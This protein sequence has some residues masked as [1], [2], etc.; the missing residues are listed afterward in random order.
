MDVEE[1]RGTGAQ[2]FVEF[3]VALGGVYPA[4]GRVADMDVGRAALDDLGGVTAGAKPRM[5]L[6]RSLSAGDLS[7]ACRVVKC[8]SETRPGREIDGHNTHCAVRYH[9]RLGF[10]RHQRELLSHDCCGHQGPALRPRSTD[11]TVLPSFSC[12]QAAFGSCEGVLGWEFP[13]SVKTLYRA[14]A[15]SCQLAY[16]NLND[17]ARHVEKGERKIN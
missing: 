8:T 10:T 9:G 5:I 16:R 1:Q 14:A 7:T 11:A 17:P 2:P 13:T 6:S 4:V 12:L 15:S 3:I